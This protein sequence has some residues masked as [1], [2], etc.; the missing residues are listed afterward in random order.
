MIEASLATPHPTSSFGVEASRADRSGF[1]F[2]RTALVV[3]LS[4]LAPNL[5]AELEA[6][7]IQTWFADSAREGLTVLLGQEPDLVLIGE[8]LDR[9]PAEFLNGVR[10]ILDRSVVLFVLEFPD[11]RRA[12][13]MLGNGAHDVLMPCCAATELVLRA[14]MARLR[15]AHVI[16]TPSNGPA[17]GTRA[18]GATGARLGARAIRVDRTSRE[19][20]DTHPRASLSRREFELLDHLDRAQ[21][22]VL[23]R[24][25]LLHAIWGKESGSEAVLDATVHRLRKK[26]ERD[27]N[28]PALLTTVR[29][30]GYRLEVGRIDFRRG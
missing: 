6:Q 23:S 5:V 29:G 13:E 25:Q 24:D 19:I 21:G 30:T 11:P 18:A 15:G 3:G 20:L 27:P 2:P 16:D 28:A 7:G 1:D 14:R 17:S 10:F 22:K 26:L 12:I 8:A 9:D 4:D